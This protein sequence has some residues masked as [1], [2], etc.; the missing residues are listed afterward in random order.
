MVKWVKFVTTLHHLVSVHPESCIC[1]QDFGNHHGTKHLLCS[2]SIFRRE[3]IETIW[4]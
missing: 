2:V 4:Y 1:V 3:R